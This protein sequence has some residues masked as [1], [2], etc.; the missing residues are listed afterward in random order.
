MGSISPAERN[1]R[2]EEFGIASHT[3]SGEETQYTPECAELK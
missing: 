3:F 1:W 2:R